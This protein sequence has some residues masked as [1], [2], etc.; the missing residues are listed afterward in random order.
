MQKMKTAWLLGEGPGGGTTLV[1]ELLHARRRRWQGREIVGHGGP[2]RSSGFELHKEVRS[3]ADVSS[4]Y[5]LQLS[6]LLKRQLLAQVEIHGSKLALEFAAGGQDLVNLG[7][8]LPFIRLIRI[9]EGLQLQILLLHLG[10]VIDQLHFVVIENLVQLRDLRI[11]QTQ[12][13]NHV[14]ILPPLSHFSPVHHDW[15]PSRMPG[16]S[17]YTAH[18]NASVLSQARARQ[19][20]C[21][22]SKYPFSFHSYEFP[23]SQTSNSRARR[24][25]A[26][27]PRAWRA[28][29]PPECR[30]A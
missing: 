25:F 5:C 30:S 23:F 27:R 15:S 2:A 21:G 29:M 10:A 20:H 1:T 19:R 12:L 22:K 26:D 28:P 8:D 4:T 16:T 9:E 11:A 14:R 18:G 17:G 24:C 7:I 6:P 13:G 3:W